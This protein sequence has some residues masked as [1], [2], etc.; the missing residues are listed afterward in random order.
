MLTTE[1][2]PANRR[3]WQKNTC[4]FLPKGGEAEH[5]FEQCSLRA[6][7]EVALDIRGNTQALTGITWRLD[8]RASLIGGKMG[9][10]PVYL[11]TTSCRSEESER[12][13]ASSPTAFLTV[14]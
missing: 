9:T 13:A 4:G 7:S 3:R 8:C 12:K 14:S 6:S 1:Q 5:P 10:A 11:A 2:I